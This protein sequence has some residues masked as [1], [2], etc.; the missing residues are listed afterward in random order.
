MSSLKWRQRLTICCE[1]I[2]TPAESII[3]IP[4][5][6]TPAQLASKPVANL[7]YRMNISIRELVRQLRCCCLVSTEHHCGAETLSVMCC[8]SGQHHTLGV[9]RPQGRRSGWE[10]RER[11]YRSHTSQLKQVNVLLLV[12]FHEAS[13]LGVRWT[14]VNWNHGTTVW[15][16]PQ[17]TPGRRRFVYLGSNLVTSSQSQS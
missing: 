15:P 6:P 17:P 16:R 5:F 4:L 8:W 1:L 10:E 7:T 12:H 11:K 2:W 13:H 9:I 3:H 14:C